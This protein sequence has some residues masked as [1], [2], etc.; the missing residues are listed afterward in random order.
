MKL[1]ALALAAIVAAT[2]ST[3]AA[4]V[5]TT[6]ITHYGPHGQVVHQEKVKVVRHPLHRHVIHPVKIVHH[7]RH[8]A[9]VRHG[10]VHYASSYHPAVRHG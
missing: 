10:K 4:T 8:Y 1:K 6:D 2:G 7:K 9:F 3:F 5:K